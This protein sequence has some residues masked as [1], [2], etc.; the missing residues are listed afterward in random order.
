MA[1]IEKIEGYSVIVFVPVNEHQPNL[2]YRVGAGADADDALAIARTIADGIKHRVGCDEIAAQNVDIEPQ[3]SV[4]CEHC[5]YRW[6]GTAEDPDYNGGCC[7]LDQDEHDARAAIAEEDAR[8]EAA[9]NG[10]F[11]VGA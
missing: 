6:H 7:A 10:P 11:G 3:I 2:A 4:E 5:G 9:N 1:K 8:E